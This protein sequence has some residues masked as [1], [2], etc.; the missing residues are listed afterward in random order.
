MTKFFKIASVAMIALMANTAFAQV[1]TQQDQATTIL[2]V[3]LEGT[4]E[5]TVGQPSVTIDMN[6]PQH[7]IAGNDS[8]VQANH[9]RVSATGDY[10]VNVSA[11]GELMFGTN[12]I[13]VN[14]VTVT[15]TVGDY[16]GAGTSTAPAAT[17]TA[18]AI[19]NGTESTIITSPTGESL[20]GFN[21]VYAIPAT[22]AAAYL[23]KPEGIY[24]TTVTYTLYSL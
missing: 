12:S 23:N 20:R 10:Q 2:N 24:T 19:Q 15:P 17:Y 3:N 4:Y 9:V 11:T 22:Q 1:T 18:Q 21:V 16:L 14:T 5:I 7:F 8:G 6:D 13:A